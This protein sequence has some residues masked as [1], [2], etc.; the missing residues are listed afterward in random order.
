[1]V[2]IDD[3]IAKNIK[4]KSKYFN[5]KSKQRAKAN[6]KNNRKRKRMPSLNIL[7]TLIENRNLNTIDLSNIKKEIT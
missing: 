3:Y 1:M 2:S 7:S 6:L 4:M 5:K